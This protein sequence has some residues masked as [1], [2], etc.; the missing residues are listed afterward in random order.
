ML[1]V[2]KPYRGRKIASNL[3]KQSL[4][5]MIEQGAD[6]IML[7]TEVVNSAAIALYEN[8]GFLRTKRLYRYYLNRNDAYRLILPVTAVSTTRSQ[9]LQHM[10]QENQEQNTSQ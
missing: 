6:E 3:V 10:N 2:K 7:E 4:S 9:F 5:I 8:M 1:A